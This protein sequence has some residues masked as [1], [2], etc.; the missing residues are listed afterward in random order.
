MRYLNYLQDLEACTVVL[1]DKSRVELT[2]TSV[3][4]VFEKGMEDCRNRIRKIM[5]E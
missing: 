2:G 5:F 4:E 3:K 1:E